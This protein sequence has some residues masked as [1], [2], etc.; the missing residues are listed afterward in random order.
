M[1]STVAAVRRFNRFYTARARLLSPRHQG[2]PF[3][4]GEMRILFEL[5]HRE[6]ATAGEL[7]RDLALDAGYVSRVLRAFRRKGLVTRVRDAADARRQL[8]TL[9]AKGRA[10]FAPLNRGAANEVRE[11]L[12]TI[13]PGRRAR[14]VTAMATIEREL[15]DERPAHAQAAFTLRQPLP[16]DLGWVVERHG[17]LYAKEYGYDHRFEGLVGT[18]VGDFAKHIDPA[19]ERCWIAVR[20]GERVGSVFLVKKTKTVAKLRLLLVE[21][22]ARGIG[23]GRALVHACTEFAREAGYAAI[24]LWTQ[25]EL[26]AARAIYVKAGYE[27][28]SK[29]AHAMFGSPAVAETWRLRL[30]TKASTK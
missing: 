19:R 2:S 13:E 25:E 9:T 27:L 29:R 1:P 15:A 21:P 17:V 20:D 7:C 18:I 30:T 11:M 28:V 24:E 14:V 5:A 4:L 26:T 12:A 16:G 6:R 8:L 10:A 23:L 3:G 22:S